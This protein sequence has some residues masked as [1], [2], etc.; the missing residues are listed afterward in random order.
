MFVKERQFLR[1]YMGRMV[2]LLEMSE[3]RTEDI[4]A[5]RN[6]VCI[7]AANGGRTVIVGNGGSAGI[8]SHLAIDFS[9]NAGIPA[10]TFSD[11]C[12]ITCL[13]NDFGFEHWLAH[14]IRLNCRGS[15]V[16]I[17]IS[18]SGR[19]ANIINGVKSARSLGMGVATLSGMAPDNPLRAMG[20][21]NLFADSRSYNLI[22]TAH[23]FWLMAVVDLII[24]ETDYQADRVVGPL[25]ETPSV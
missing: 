14:A 2:D 3:T 18:S 6:M 24:G 7:A 22:E 15:D 11:P 20:D 21:V 19:S 13:A 23:Q 10:I 8:A 16:L 1:S 12:Q 4:C 9:K 5:V 25:A 17:A